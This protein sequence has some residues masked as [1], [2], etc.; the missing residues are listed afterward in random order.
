[1]AD[2]TPARVAVVDDNPATLYST[3]RVLRAAGFDVTEG[4]SGEEALELASKGVDILLLDVN[5]PDIHGFEVCR[6]LRGNPRTVRL[7]VVHVSAT[8]V[9]EINKA[10]G[11]DAGGDGY[12]TH[13][14]EPPVLVATVN[15]FLRARRAEDEMRK[16]EAKFKAVF[17]NAP[18]GILLLDQRLT[19]LEVNP[20]MCELLSRPREEIV[21]KPLSTFMPQGTTANPGEIE[22]ALEGKGTWRG[23][24][25]LFRSDGL[26][27]HLEWYISAHSFPGVRLAVVTDITDRIRLETE[28]DELLASER[29]A[30]AE[31]ERASHL[32]DEFLGTLSHELRTPLNSILLWT[33]MLS[34]RSQDP[35]RMA[36][37]L[38][39]IERSTKVQAQLIADLLDV[40]G[41]VSGK[42][43]L[44]V[45]PLDLA[46]TIRAALESLLPA[47]DAKELKLTT[48][49][50]PR[51]A[52]I[53]G[54]P[55]RLQ[56]VVWNLINNASKFTPNGGSIEVRMERVGSQVEVSI[57]D[58]GQGIAPELLPYLFE[59]FRQGDVSTRRK[60]GGLGLGLAIVKHIVE[61]HG[62]TVSASSAGPGTGAKFTVLLPIAASLDDSL[63]I[64]PDRESGHRGENA[65]LENVNVLVVD[66]DADT[67][68]VMSRILKQTGAIVTTATDVGAALIELERSNP[69]VLVS[70]IGM[71]ER[72][73]YDL[74]RE[75]RAR[76]HSYQK[77][78]AIALTALASPQDRRRALLAG[79][80]VHLSKPI[81][82]DELTAT[83]AALVGRTEHNS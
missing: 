67:C 28:R 74:I 4:A 35:E 17:D 20:A 34:Q 30:R 41:I 82:A 77:L 15:A 66:D 60:S 53:S 21:G 44:D 64:S 58:T 38:A 45:Q 24:F 79:Y 27:V 73:G 2:R 59:R 46:S 76:G 10:E 5:L 55:S 14:V 47:I 52:M 7:P 16:S 42:L 63:H 40:S 33:Q 12:L 72:D 23:V 1:M 19:Y 13:P 62:G 43:R 81:D 61:M 83:I 36:R 50:D 11:L 78:P 8:F 49:F 29:A 32:K 70:D 56:Q 65:R 26:L 51:V 48:R 37:G 69:Q 9:K 39:A 18:S 25:P 71:P 80:Q 3:S 22:S 75:V 68:S 54:D 6:R 57:S 31:A